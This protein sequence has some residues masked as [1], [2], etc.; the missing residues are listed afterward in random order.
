[1][2]HKIIGIDLGTTNSVIAVMEG[3]SV[4]VLPDEK[5]EKLC[6]SVVAVLE[7]NHSPLIGIPA[8]NQLVVNPKNT[9]YSIKRFMGRRHNEVA[10]EEKLVSYDILGGPEEMVRVRAGNREFTPPQVS[11]LILKSLK[12]RAEKYLG[13]EVKKA[14]VTVPAYFND[15]Q[16]QATKDAG[17]LAGLEVERIL[18]EPTAAALAYG[19]A[20]KQVSKIAVFDLGG[21]TFD[22]SILELSN[23]V[24]Q[25]LSTNG[26]THLGGDD[27]DKRIVD[28][29]YAVFE[30]ENGFA[31][32]RLPSVF[33]RVRQ[34]AER[35]KCALS[36][37]ERTE[38]N[39]P[40]L[41]TQNGK[42]F[43]FNQTLAR[44]ELEALVQDV[45][46]RA[47]NPCRRAMDD[48]NLTPD[49]IDEVI[50]VGGSTRMPMV[51]ELVRRVFQKEPNTSVNPDEVVA[52][53]AAIQGAVLSGDV[54]DI[55]LL[56][57][58]PLSLGIETY[59]GALSKL[60]FRNSPIPAT[61]K[62]VF[63]TAVD[64]QT[65]IDVHVLQG[66][67]EMAA[68]NRTLARFA[69]SGIQPQPAGVPRIEVTFTI[70]VNAI[71]SVSAKDLA[72]GK[73]EHI[74][75]RPVYGL[76]EEEISRQVD[77]SVEHAFEDMDKRM[78]VDHKQEAEKVMA[79]TEKALLQCGDKLEAAP[80]DTIVSLLARTKK[81]LE[82]GDWHE[83]KGAL[84]A[85]NQGTIHLAEVLV[86][87]AIKG[88][89][90]LPAPESN[91]PLP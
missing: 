50:L 14:I 2:T 76:T 65:A 57:V 67:R 77:E 62:E 59:G 61:A 10:D 28:W 42:V 52:I 36:F 11:S 56:D 22:I 9:I 79:A 63:T 23:G 53:G 3:G 72:T 32:S 60:I 25:V 5:N 21:G 73:A 7:G 15:S 58:N 6:P 44:P 90:N 26:D 78:W 24:F 8:R 71:L 43:N 18:N 16:R 49:R 19:L 84:D 75:V 86:A 69:L 30:K 91:S 87:E 64:N 33:E 41:D 13:T 46:G 74:E 31:L 45:V 55:L 83:L 81:A 82:G 80:R 29:V 89:S 70:D 88:E 51:R 85:L 20:R 68:D 47:T 40:L 34:E 66:E 35:V 12:E 1:M 54:A 17:T 37:A 4:T 38:F 48:A 39:L 27:I